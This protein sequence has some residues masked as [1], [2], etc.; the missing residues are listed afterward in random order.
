MCVFIYIYFC[1]DNSWRDWHG[2]VHDNVNV[3]G[4]GGIDLLCCCCGRASTETCC[5]EHVRNTEPGLMKMRINSMP[6]KN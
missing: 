6:N 5:F 3:L 1:Y 2:N 4:L